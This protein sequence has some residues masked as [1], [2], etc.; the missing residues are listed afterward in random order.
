MRLH[1]RYDFVRLEATLEA[2]WQ[3]S[4]DGE[5]QGTPAP[6]P[7]PPCAAGQ[8]VEVEVVVRT[9]PPMPRYVERWLTLRFR[10]KSDGHEVGWAQLPC[11]PEPAEPGPELEGSPVEEQVL[12]GGRAEAAA[13]AEEEFAVEEAEGQVLVRGSRLEGTLTLFRTL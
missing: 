3:W 6:L 7:L 10:R 9:S 1:N 4:L 13:A 11:P 12:V 8:T 2:E 5:L